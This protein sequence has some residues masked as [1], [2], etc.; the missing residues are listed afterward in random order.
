MR[1]QEMREKDRLSVLHVGHASHGNFQVGFGLQHERVDQR[2]ESAAN[3]GNGI[4][5]E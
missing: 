3:F 2:E 4:D 1:H 5:Y